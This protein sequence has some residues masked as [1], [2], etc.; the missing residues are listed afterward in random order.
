MKK[1]LIYTA[2][3]FLL[4]FLLFSS[5]ALYN[6]RNRHKG[7][8]MDKE[9]KGHSNGPIRAG[10]A[11]LPITPEVPDTW[12]DANGDARYNPKDG[13]TWEDGNG[14]GKFDAVWIAG[15]HNK[16]PAQGIHDDLWARTMILD[17]G[18]T[19]IAL[20]SI[21]VIG[22]FYDDVLDVRKQLKSEAGID[23]L[24]IASTHTHE[25]PDLMGIWGKSPLKSGVDPEYLQY[26]KNQIVSSVEQAVAN[27]RPARLLIAQDHERGMETLA[28]TRLP[29]VFDPGIRLIQAIDRETDQTLGTLFAWANH[30]ETLWSQNLLITSDFP[31]YVREYVENGIYHNDSLVTP[32]I[33]GV[34]VYIN[35][36]IGGLMTTHPT[37]P[38]QDPFEDTI[39]LK[40]SFDK[41]RAQGQIIAQIGLDALKDN[42]VEIS[43]G[44]ISLVA[45]TVYFRMDNTLFRLGGSLGVI[46]R[47]VKGWKTIQSEIA[48][49]SLG[50]MSFLNMPGEIYPEIVNGGVEA[51]EGRDFNIDPIEVPPLRSLMPGDFRFVVGLANDEIGYVLP[52]SQWDTKAPYAYGREKAQYGEVNSMGPET[53]PIFHRESVKVIEQLKTIMHK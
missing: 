39:Y 16:K 48:A 42:P 37:T 3:F 49:W 53:G 25:G 5:F 29:H 41:A 44:S 9:I 22:F 27:I 50:P 33:G 19:R 36:A 32:G 46:K 51:P 4:I 7:Y 8:V 23:Y 21:D 45:K 47:S 26:V 13:D 18:S 14:N 20:I 11:A 28:D 38:V 10:F 43:E 35:G 12:H 34:T 30:P 6:M 17:D 24:T 15:F 1:T 40:P 2:A 52:K 31:H